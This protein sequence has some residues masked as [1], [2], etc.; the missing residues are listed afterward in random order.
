MVTF[1]ALTGVN[2][3]GLT[4]FVTFAAWN[5]AFGLAVIPMAIWLARRY[6]DRLSKVKA[7]GYLADSIAG[8]DIAAVRLFLEKL[9]RFESEAN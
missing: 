9:R 1:A 4:K 7:I 6:G 5:L 8:R 3:Y 2:L